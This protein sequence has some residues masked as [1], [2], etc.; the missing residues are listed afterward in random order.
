LLEPA[1]VKP[2][3]SGPVEFCGTAGRA[4]VGL[5]AVDGRLSTG[6]QTVIVT[7]VSE[8]SLAMALTFSAELCQLRREHQ[9][10]RQT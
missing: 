10:P 8:A 5:I 3:F 4:L 2:A 1:L 9:Y 6:E 7:T